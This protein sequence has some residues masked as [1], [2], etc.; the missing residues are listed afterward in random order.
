MQIS[1]FSS[2]PDCLHHLF[3]WIV[4]VTTQEKYVVDVAQEQV[5]KRV[6]SFPTGQNGEALAELLEA[7]GVQG[8][9]ST[10]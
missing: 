10:L 1:L 7:S 4:P 9:P 3:R 6:V 8:Q 5:S 2:Q